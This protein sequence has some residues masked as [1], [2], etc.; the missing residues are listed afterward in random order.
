[1]ARSLATNFE[2]IDSELLDIP[3]LKIVRAPDARACADTDAVHRLHHSR[4]S[5][6]GFAGRDVQA[7]PN[8][9]FRHCRAHQLRQ[10][11]GVAGDGSRGVFCS[12]VS[13]GKW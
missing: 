3:R 8:N 9:R 10:P 4:R 13:Q 6:R 5:V 2:S 11:R 1:M 7:Q 12:G